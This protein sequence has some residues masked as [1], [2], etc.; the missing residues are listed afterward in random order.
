MS[1]QTIY[2][3]GARTAAAPAPSLR[4]R[5]RGWMRRA[6]Q[7]LVGLG[8]PPRL[9]G[10]RWTRHLAAADVAGVTEIHPAATARAP[11][12]RMVARR[13]DLPDERGWFGY[14]FRDVPERR[15]G[16]TRLLRLAEARVLAARPGR[17]YAPAILNARGRSLDLREIRYRPFHAPLAARRPDLTLDRA[18]WF[19]ERVYDNHAHW[20]TAHLPKLAQLVELGETA[21]LVLPAERTPVIDHSLALLGIDPA[22]QPELPSGAVLA[23][24]ELVLLETDRFRPELLRLARRMT[25]GEGAPGTRRVFVSRRSARGRRLVDEEAL[26]PMLRDFGFEIVEMERLDFPAQIALMREAGALLAPHGAGLA[27][28]LFCA[29]GTRVIEIADPAYP[30]PN[31]YAQAVGLGLDYALV[32]GRGVGGGHPLDQDLAVD[33][34]DLRRALETV[35]G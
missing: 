29:E 25:V 18:V 22:T 32:R 10:Y 8:L 15:A 19:A 33:E 27:N 17:D 5:A 12:P 23:T 2:Q 31:F 26:T 7:R 24:R 4:G 9:V 6:G 34:A 16:P 1:R 13:E 11:L 30:N 20:L 28:M 21:D 3:A 35:L 14:A